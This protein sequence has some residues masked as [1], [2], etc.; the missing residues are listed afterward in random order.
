[1]SLALSVKQLNQFVADRQLVAGIENFYADDVAMV[2]SGGEPMVGK[3]ANRE[4]ER[5]FESGL[6]NW[7]AKLLASAVDESTGTA[8]NQWVIDYD[9]AQWGS[10]TLRQVAVQQWRDGR[11]VHE[12][13]YKI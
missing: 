12:A 6:T 1:M 4:R 8:L 2:E 7:S 10:G 5:A 11:I 3:E 9:H 13:F